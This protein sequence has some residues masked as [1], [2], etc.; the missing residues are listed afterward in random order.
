MFNQ[1]LKTLISCFPRQLSVIFR[2]DF[3]GVT[4]IYQVSEIALLLKL[5]HKDRY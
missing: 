4:I 5:N 3:V 2:N 1:V